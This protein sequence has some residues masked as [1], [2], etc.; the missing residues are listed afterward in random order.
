M[1]VVFMLSVSSVSFLK[2]YAH[3]VCSK[4]LL[5]KMCNESQRN[6]KKNETKKTKKD[7]NN[8]YFL[9]SINSAINTMAK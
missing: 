3:G 5:L 9:F 4:R 2:S 8:L 1:Y 7:K 6:E